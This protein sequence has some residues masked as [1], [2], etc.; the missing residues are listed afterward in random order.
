MQGMQI[1]SNVNDQCVM[2][3]HKAI[4]RG[5]INLVKSLLKEVDDINAQDEFGFAP[6]HLAAK[7]DNVALVNLLLKRGANIEC[8][9]RCNRRTPLH[10][11]AYY[12]AFH[13]VKFL[14]KQGANI[15]AKNEYQATPLHLADRLEVIEILIREGADMD[16]KNDLGL[17]PMH[18][19]AVNGRLNVVKFLLTKTRGDEGPNTHL[20]LAVRFELEHLFKF[21]LNEGVDI[22][23][24]DQDG[25]TA[26]E[27]AILHEKSVSILLLSSL[28]AKMNLTDVSL[29]KLRDIVV[30]LI[31]MDSCSCLEK[32]SG[33]LHIL[34]HLT[35][36][37]S[38]DA[39]KE[40]CI[41]EIEEV[42]ST[43]LEPIIREAI[44]LI[45]EQK[46]EGNLSEFS[47]LCLSVKNEYVKYFLDNISPGLSEE[48]NVVDNM[49]ITPNL[50]ALGN[51]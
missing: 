9:D 46:E 20:H 18:S 10:E 16:A 12:G 11:A 8:E 35:K 5:N 7:T 1:D 50:E 13:V 3:I 21:F 26:L 24:L 2:D 45:K 32:I 31:T 40:V 25:K 47:G 37:H 30:S 22:N 29:P 6:L 17:T 49:D 43:G 39:L 38:T 41:R 51:I 4:R 23:S 19:A 42:L 33:L 34:S 28:G 36:L 44:P 48:I 15:H 14:L 27:Y